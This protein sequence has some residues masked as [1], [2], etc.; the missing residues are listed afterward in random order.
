[1]D[2]T[3][4]VDSDQRNGNE[5]DPERLKLLMLICSVVILVERVK[6]FRLEKEL[7]VQIVS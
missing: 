4:Q 1:M 6:T 3:E 5:D 2:T 7:K